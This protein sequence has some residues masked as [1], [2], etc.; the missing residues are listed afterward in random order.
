M[1]YAAARHSAIAFLFVGVLGGCARDEAE[2]PTPVAI[3][4]PEEYAGLLTVGTFAGTTKYTVHIDGGGFNPDLD[5]ITYQQDTLDVVSDGP[6]ERLLTFRVSGSIF[7]GD[8][9]G[10]NGIIGLNVQA[11]FRD[12][13]PDTVFFSRY[14]GGAMYSTRTNFVGGRIP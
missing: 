14:Q 1:K 2:A 12:S 3:P 6:G 10:Q 7:H 13:S 8:T 4:E 11:S 9:I 5:S